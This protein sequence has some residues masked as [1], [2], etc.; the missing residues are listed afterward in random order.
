MSVDFERENL[1][2]SVFLQADQDEQEK[3]WMKE[4]QEE[5]R[6]PAEIYVRVQKPVKNEFEI[7]TLPF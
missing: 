1:K 3:Q 5:N 7:N 2:E 4:I 6:Q